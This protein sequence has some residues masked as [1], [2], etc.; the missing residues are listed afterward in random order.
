MKKSF[1][2][3]IAGASA[4][5]T[6]FGLI[7]RSS[8]LI[9]ESLYANYF[10]LSNDFDHYLIAAVFPLSINLVVIFIVQN[11]VVPNYLREKNNSIA[12]AREFSN[13]TLWM[14]GISGLIIS[15][16]LFYFSRQIINLY[17]PN[18][19][20]E[21]L[22]QTVLIFRIFIFTIPLNAFY[23]VFAS[24]LHSELQFK[25]PMYS[26]LLLNLVIIIF[27]L[28]FNSQLRIISIPIGYLIGTFIQLLYLYIKVRKYLIPNFKRFLTSN[29]FAFF[30]ST[31]LFLVVIEILGQSYSIIDRYFFEHIDEGGIAALNYAFILF[32]LPIIII[33]YALTTVLFPTFSKLSS[34]KSFDEIS[35]HLQNFF[36]IN[37]F[38][39]IPISIVLILYGDFFVKIIFEHGEFDN[40]ATTLTYN[41]LKL[42]SLSYIFISSYFVLNKLF[43]SFDKIKSLFLITI[44]GILIKVILSFQLVTNYKQDGLALSTSFTYLFFFLA[45]YCLIFKHLNFKNVQIFFVETFFLGLIGFFA[46]S[47]MRFI[48]IELLFNSE[49]VTNCLNIILLLV[50]Y[51]TSA[52]FVKHRSITLIFNM[53]NN[54]LGTKLKVA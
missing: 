25:Q 22:N 24:V 38:I 16:I 53:I 11:Y 28:V 6:I 30:S 43:Y 10:G 4:F 48:G 31:F 44:I 42:Y 21:S 9:R 18:S 29:K 13:S 19:D 1:T 17:L 37:L 47:L 27:V 33:A 7:R 39:F 20:I 5:I 3:T 35:N 54:Y 2:A 36:S 34:K 45:S 26:Q 23:S 32:N 15:L 40:R 52:L 46:Y 49:L 51:F 8:G 14:F 41:A 12:S 50:F